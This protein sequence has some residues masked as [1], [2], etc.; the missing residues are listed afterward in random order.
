MVI[1]ESDWMPFLSMSLRSTWHWQDDRL[2]GHYY[3]IFCVQQIW[4]ITK[5]HL[6]RETSSVHYSLTCFK[7]TTQK[8]G[9]N[10]E[11]RNGW[12]KWKCNS[13]PAGKLVKREGRNNLRVNEKAKKKCNKVTIR[14]QLFMTS[15]QTSDME[16]V[17]S[18]QQA[19]SGSFADT[20]R[21][22]QIVSNRWCHSG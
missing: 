22:R 21:R 2:L 6:I 15:T 17:K 13:K 9:G 12:K 3:F 8:Y 16:S 18:Q 19:M 1:V 5:F 7:E 20:V 14:S 4:S 11:E 10:A